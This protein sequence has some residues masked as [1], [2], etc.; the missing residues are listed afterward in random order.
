VKTL[1]AVV[2]IAAVCAAT[3]L[4]YPLFIVVRSR[5]PSIVR[6][7]HAA[8]AR[9]LG[10]H[11]TVDGTP[12]RGAFLLVSNHLSYV[13]VVVL[14]GLIETLFV[15]K[16][17]VRDW[18]ALGPLASS[19]GTVFIDRES[20]RDAVR[21]TTLL[22][23]LVRGGRAIV[24]F[25]EGTSTDG[26]DVLPFNTPLFE[27]AADDALPVWYAALRYAQPEV[28]WFGDATFTSHLRTLLRLPRIDVRVSFGGPLAP[29][30]RKSLARAAREAIVALSSRA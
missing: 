30:D 12:P 11:I 16:A 13:D 14:G 25:P 6:R 2:R 26:S 22:R 24:V 8:V 18:P 29:G 4:L 5:R 15:A 7:W 23:E 9:I 19:T 17:D 10:I 1:R 21:V 27:A 28:P 3:T 20:R